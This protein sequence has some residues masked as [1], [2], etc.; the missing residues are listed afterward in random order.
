MVKSLLFIEY[1]LTFLLLW[2]GIIIFASISFIK[3]QEYK[4]LG[5][6]LPFVVA[7][8]YIFYKYIIKED[9]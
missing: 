6:V 4:M 1:V 8:I 2:F 5:V 9:Y 7:G 3:N